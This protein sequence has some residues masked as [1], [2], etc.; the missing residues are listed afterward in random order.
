MLGHVAALSASAL[1]AIASILF[2]RLRTSFSAPALNVLK[3]GI[4][5]AMMLVTLLVLNGRLWPTSMSNSETAWLALSGIIGLT[6]GDT[7]LFEALSRIGPRRSLLFMTLAPPITAL[8]AWPV[9]D[10]PVTVMMAV[11]IVV[12]IVG[13]AMVIGDRSGEDVASVSM[14]GYLFAI[15]S[16]ICQA[17]GNIAT[18]LGGAHD[19]LE[20]SIV[21]TAFGALTLIIYLSFRFKISEEL[22][23]AKSWSVLKTVIIA[24]ILGTYLGIWL[25]VTGLRFAPA[26]IAA[27]LSSTSPIFVLPLAAIFLGDTIR[28]R[29][30]VAALI[31]VIGIALLFL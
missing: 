21:R 25:Q 3:T 30:V 22:A 2:T 29:T 12:T 13:V 17:T 4:A 24:T 10:E 15:G 5:C 14:V 26:G 9:L 27:T 28:A 18:K 6:I 1:W 31:A 19:P 16:A 8:I 7:L 11:G 23:P 20:M